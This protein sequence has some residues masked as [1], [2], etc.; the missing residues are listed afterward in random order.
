M[1]ACR[2]YSPKL[3]TFVLIP[4]QFRYLHN[5]FEMYVLPRAGRPTI[6]ITCGLFTKFAR[7]PAIKYERFRILRYYHPRDRFNFHLFVSHFI[8]G[9]IRLISLLRRVQFFDLYTYCTIYVYWVSHDI[10]RVKL[11]RRY[12]HWSLRSWRSSNVYRVYSN[13][14]NSRRDRKE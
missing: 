11:C 7:S 4:I 8:F 2:L 5:F 3:N 9:N 12:F 13:S 14:A 1:V 6:A 10:A